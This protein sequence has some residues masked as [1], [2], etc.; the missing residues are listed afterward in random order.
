MWLHFNSNNMEEVTYA[1]LKELPETVRKSNIKAT[2][3]QCLSLKY[4]CLEFNTV[5][6]TTNLAKYLSLTDET[7][8]AKEANGEVNAPM[9]PD[10]IMVAA[11]LST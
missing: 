7:I 3:R 6:N 10:P 4:V 9:L 2:L 5:T 1:C 8:T 11:R